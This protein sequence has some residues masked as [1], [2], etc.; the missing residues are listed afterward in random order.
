MRKRVDS[1]IIKPDFLVSR[2]PGHL[3]FYQPIIVLF[4][5]FRHS[6][7]KCL[8]PTGYKVTVNIMVTIGMTASSLVL[9]LMLELL[10]HRMGLSE[11]CLHV[12]VLSSLCKLSSLRNIQIFNLL[13]K[14]DENAVKTNSDSWQHTYKRWETLVSNFRRESTEQ[15]YSLTKFRQETPG[16]NSHARNFCSKPIICHRPM[17]WGACGVSTGCQRCFVYGA[18][19]NRKVIPF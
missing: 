12:S 7:T 14:S 16:E 1:C 9:F 15:N 4:P 3:E 19:V 13:V 2:K 17:E 8:Y 6:V 11:P 5:V 10:F 18:V